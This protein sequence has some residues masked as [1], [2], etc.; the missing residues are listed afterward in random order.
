[1]EVQWKSDNDNDYDHDFIYNDYDSCFKGL[2]D[3]VRV[4]TG[5]VD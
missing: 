4:S 5:Y 3:K 2:C 1:M